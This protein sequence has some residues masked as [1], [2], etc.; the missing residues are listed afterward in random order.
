MAAISRPHKLY[1]YTPAMRGKYGLMKN[2]P[3]CA[4]THLF[5][6][7][8]ATTRKHLPQIIFTTTLIEAWYGV[9]AMN[10]QFLPWSHSTLFPGPSPVVHL[11]QTYFGILARWQSRIVLKG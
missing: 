11:V 9:F 4:K 2:G 1:H 7:E 5:L 6:T 10:Y 8:R 3:R